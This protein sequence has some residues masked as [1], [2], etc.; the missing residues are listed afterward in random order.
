MKATGTTS[1]SSLKVS[2]K[3]NR[4]NSS[5]TGEGGVVERACSSLP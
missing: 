5:D 1:C 4:E 2:N 3:R